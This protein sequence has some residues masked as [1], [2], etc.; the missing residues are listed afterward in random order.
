MSLVLGLLELIGY[1]EWTESLGPDRE[2][3]IQILQSQLYAELQ[4]IV[5]MREGFL[6]PLSMDN[7]ILVLN[8]VPQKYYREIFDEA[9]RLSPVPVGL[10]TLCVRDPVIELYPYGEPGLRIKNASI[11]GSIA[12]LHIDLDYFS[13]LRVR[14]GS[15]TSY[16]KILDYYS[17]ISKRLSGLPAL[18]T[19]LGGDNML[20]FSTK[21]SIDKIIEIIA[22]TINEEK[23]KIGVG[24][25]ET[26]RRALSLA[27]RALEDLRKKRKEH[28]KRIVIKEE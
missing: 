24:I 11:G 23:Y 6:V 5:A 13:G 19:Y 2:W 3:N 7:M 12:A 15:I 1:R 8:G 20:V 27:A 26:P 22:K 25:A 14:A 18:A 17:R 16:V 10:T 21:N 9:S 4:K 28:T